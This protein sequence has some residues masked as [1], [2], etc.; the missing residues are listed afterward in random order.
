MPSECDRP[1][2]KFR[3]S[4][5]PRQSAFVFDMAYPHS[6]VNGVECS[7]L[8]NGSV[9]KDSSISPADFSAVPIFDDIGD[10]KTYAVIP[11]ACSIGISFRNVGPTQKYI[12]VRRRI[13]TCSVFHHCTCRY[14]CSSTS[15][16]S[17][18]PHR[19]A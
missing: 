18:T 5:P 11:G 14:A 3:R 15:K 16:Q 4:E 1:A 9:E 6:I 17:K 8:A 12:E 7:F 13:G 2:H 19:A 10:S